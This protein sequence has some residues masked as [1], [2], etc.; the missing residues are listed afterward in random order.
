LIE[1]VGGY[2]DVSVDGVVAMIDT[3][4]VGRGGSLITLAV[5]R[6]LIS[7]GGKTSGG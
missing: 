4:R 1:F 2:L 7:N 6:R 5:E 3:L